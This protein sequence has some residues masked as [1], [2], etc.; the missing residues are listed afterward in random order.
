VSRKRRQRSTARKARIAK[1]LREQ[2]RKGKRSDGGE[3]GDAE[4]LWRF[5]VSTPSARG[6]SHA[7]LDLQRRLA[8]TPIRGWTENDLAGEHGLSWFATALTEGP[9]DEREVVVDLPYLAKQDLLDRFGALEVA[10]DGLDL[11]WRDCAQVLHALTQ[12]ALLGDDDEDDE[13]DG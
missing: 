4:R 11:D 8:L 1:Y 5:V 7:L 10:A 2:K 9:M 12:T 3:G 6:C 13:D